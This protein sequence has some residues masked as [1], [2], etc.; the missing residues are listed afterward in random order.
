ME[1]AE[2]WLSSWVE[3]MVR[4][5]LAKTGATKKP[6]HAPLEKLSD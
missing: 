2:K 4:P 3:R 6:K 1:K 5:E